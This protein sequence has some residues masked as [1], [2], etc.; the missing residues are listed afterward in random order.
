MSKLAL[1]K[2]KKSITA[3]VLYI[4]KAKEFPNEVICALLII[5]RASVVLI[6]S[7]YRK[8]LTIDLPGYLIVLMQNICMKMVKKTIFSWQIEIGDFSYF[9]VFNGLYIFDR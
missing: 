1:E 6:I 7:S 3:D 8:Y 9:F 5:D 4:E 2:V